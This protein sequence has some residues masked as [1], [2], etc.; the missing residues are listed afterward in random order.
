M[1]KPKPKRAGHHL[2]IKNVKTRSTDCAI[3]KRVALC[4]PVAGEAAGGT[5]FCDTT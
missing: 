3:V 5:A 4:R 2:L 1:V